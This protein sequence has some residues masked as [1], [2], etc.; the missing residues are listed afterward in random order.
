MK[1][2]IRTLATIFCLF[3]FYAYSRANGLI[4]C[5]ADQTVID[6]ILADY[7]VIQEVD[8]AGHSSFFRIEVDGDW[9]EFLESSLLADDRVVWVESESPSGHSTTSGP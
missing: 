2:Q 5:L 6:S 4:V 7:P 3:F 8:R 9:A 1:N